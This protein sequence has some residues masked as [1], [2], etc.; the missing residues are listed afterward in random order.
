MRQYLLADLLNGFVRAGLAI[1]QVAETGDRG[2][3]TIL[4][5]RARKAA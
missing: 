3:P 2:V 1:E 4:A 5:V